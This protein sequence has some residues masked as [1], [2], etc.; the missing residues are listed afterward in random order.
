MASVKAEEW[1]EI[2]RMTVEAYSHHTKW[3]GGALA[4]YLLEDTAAVR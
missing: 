4:Y 2:V 1:P 3:M